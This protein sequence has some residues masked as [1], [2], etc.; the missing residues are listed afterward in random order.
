MW[1]ISCCVVKC[2]FLKRPSRL[3]PSAQFSSQRAL[4]LHNGRPP[5]GCRTP[6]PHTP[7]LLGSRRHLSINHFL[8]PLVCSHHDDGNNQSHD[9]DDVNLDWEE[10]LNSVVAV[11]DWTTTTRRRLSGAVKD[12]AGQVETWRGS[13]LER[14]GTEWRDA[15][16][17]CTLTIHSVWWFDVPSCTTRT[18]C[19]RI[20]NLQHYLPFTVVSSS[21]CFRSSLPSQCNILKWDGREVSRGRQCVALPINQLLGSR[22]IVND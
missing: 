2:A 20:H 15:H 11:L 22:S 12:T 17:H 4:Q 10:L 3:L 5:R 9:T 16:R 18:Q 14:C 1:F 21:I 19:N 7:S 8:L 13:G 6:V